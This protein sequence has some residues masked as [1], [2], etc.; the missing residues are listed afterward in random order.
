MD[1]LKYAPV[2]TFTS[3]ELKIYSRYMKSGADADMFGVI[4]A[5]RTYQKLGVQ[6]RYMQSG[7][8]ADMFRIL[9]GHIPLT[10]ASPALPRV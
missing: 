6:S 3:L 7:I 5:F 8:D 9:Q 10:P 1:I 2:P 4:T